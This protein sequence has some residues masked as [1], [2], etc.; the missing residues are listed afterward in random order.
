MNKFQNLFYLEVNIK[1]FS[2]TFQAA[3]IYSWINISSNSNNSNPH[4]SANNCQALSPHLH[5]LVTLACVNVSLLE[6]NRDMSN[7]WAVTSCILMKVDRAKY[8]IRRTRTSDPEHGQGKGQRQADGHVR[9]GQGQTNRN[10]KRETRNVQRVMIGPFSYAYFINYQ[11]R[12][13][14]TCSNN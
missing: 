4:Q 12:R 7:E 8:A 13:G 10:V 2:I 6:T 14:K 11:Q 9:A 3:F 1:T 5:N